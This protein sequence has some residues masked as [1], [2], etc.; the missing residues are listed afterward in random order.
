MFNSQN[1]D[2]HQ[3][4]QKIRRS[5]DFGIMIGARGGEILSKHHKKSVVWVDGKPLLSI[6]NK[7]GISSIL[8]PDQ[9]LIPNNEAIGRLSEV[10]GNPSSFRLYHGNDMFS[11]RYDF[12]PEHGRWFEKTYVWYDATRALRKY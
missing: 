2:V 8:S 11:A 9:E 4:E 10:V 12:V 5:G 1:L 3:I 7:V 6:N